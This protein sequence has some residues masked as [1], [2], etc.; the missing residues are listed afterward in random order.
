M[1]SI[2]KVNGEKD[3]GVHFDPHFNFQEHDNKKVQLANKNLGLIAKPFATCPRK[4]F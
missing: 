2:N 4:R 3:I 1:N